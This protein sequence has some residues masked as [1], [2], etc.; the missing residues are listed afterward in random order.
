MDIMLQ[1]AVVFGLI[2][3][4]LLLAGLILW[5]RTKRYIDRAHKAIGV[6]IKLRK[7]PFENRETFS[8]VVRFT[9]NDGR[10]LSFTDPIARYP[11]EFEVGERTHVLYDPNNPHKARAVKRLSDLFLSAKLFGSASAALLALGLLSGIV[12]GLR[13]YFSGFF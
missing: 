12:F 3:V 1:F 7:V 2:M 11:A 10:A 4:G 8:P 13:N 5:Y 9:T 6:V